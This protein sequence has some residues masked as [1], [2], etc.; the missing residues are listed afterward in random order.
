MLPQSTG[1]FAEDVHV[2]DVAV[3]DALN[4]ADW[5]VDERIFVKHKQPVVGQRDDSVRSRPTKVLHTFAV[6]LLERYTQSV[7]IALD[8]LLGVDFADQYRLQS[9]LISS[10]TTTGTAH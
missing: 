5:N 2:K 3:L 1:I 4:D 7:L 9:V 10:A 6:Q 8:R